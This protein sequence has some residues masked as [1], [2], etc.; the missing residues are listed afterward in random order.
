ML[1]S[2][3]AQRILR[4]MTKI[5]TIRLDPELLGKAE[6][7]AAGMGLDR[8]KYVRALIEEDLASVRKSLPRKFASEHLAGIYV[9]DGQSATNASTRD[10]L[11]HRAADK[12]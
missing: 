2:L 12:P 1:T 3:S 7:R 9:G 8:A 5:L 11:K 10:R 6:A 4:R